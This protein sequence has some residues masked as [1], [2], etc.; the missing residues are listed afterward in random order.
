MSSQVDLKY[1]IGREQ[2]NVVDSVR[3]RVIFIIGRP[4]MD[5]R[6][7]HRTYADK[8]VSWKVNSGAL[9]L[10]SVGIL[11]TPHV[12]ANRL[13]TISAIFQLDHEVLLLY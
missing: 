13:L 9:Y 5:P 6:C 2:K 8:A 10:L 1:A 12:D 4:E 11:W 7:I 3:T